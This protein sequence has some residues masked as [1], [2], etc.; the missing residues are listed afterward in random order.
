MF[1]KYLTKTGGLSSRQPEGIKNQWYTQKFKQIHGDSYDYSK[2]QYAN[3]IT[4]VLIICK[5]HGGFYQIPKAHLQGQG[6]PK[7]FKESKSL[8]TQ[9]FI[10]KSQS[11]HGNTYDYSEVCYTHSHSPVVILCPIHGQ[12][13]QLQRA[14]LQGKGCPKCGNQN[15]DT[16][17]LI[18][19]LKTGTLKIGI[20]NNIN[21]RVQTI[22]GFTE[23]VKQI[24][25]THPRQCEKYLHDKYY[26]YREYNPGVKSGNTEFFQLTDE[27]VHEVINYF[28][29]VQQEE[30]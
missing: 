4:K 19:C 22:G 8:S 28:N 6:C 16:L 30:I 12:F 2:I 1:E 29:S 9:D 14:H 24:Y 21:K 25:C 15:Q 11:I 3:T 17:Y 27:Q 5:K 23:L 7:C 13:T 26:M 10:E 18:R 20:T